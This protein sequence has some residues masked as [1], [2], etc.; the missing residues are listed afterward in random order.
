MEAVEVVKLV[1][2]ESIPKQATTGISSSSFHTC[3]ADACHPL[4]FH[5]CLLLLLPQA[6]AVFFPFISRVDLSLRV[7]SSRHASRSPSTPRCH[8]KQPLSLISS[9]RLLES[10]LTINFRFIRAPSGSHIHLRLFQSNVS[11]WGLCQSA[12][13]IL[14]DQTQ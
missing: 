1:E 8:T 9:S 4:L 11:F 6:S 13:L 10:I 7:L 12:V 5:S 14:A 3:Y 2:R